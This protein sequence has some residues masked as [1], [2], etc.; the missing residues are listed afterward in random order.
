MEG[1]RELAPYVPEILLW[2]WVIVT[3]W[4]AIMKMSHLTDNT[5]QTYLLAAIFGLLLIQTL[6]LS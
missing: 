3:G 4:T 6:H 1:L 2:G 5:I